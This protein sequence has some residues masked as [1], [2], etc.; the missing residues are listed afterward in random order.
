L[1]PFIILALE[2]TIGVMVGSATG[3]ASTWAKPGHVSARGERAWTGRRAKLRSCGKNGSG[4]GRSRSGAEKVSTCEFV[5]MLHI[6]LGCN[7]M[8]ADT[9]EGELGS[10][11]SGE[12]GAG[13]SI[14]GR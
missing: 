3:F 14:G 9:R 13:D 2:T 11:P 5:S 10:S 4:G 1:V 7:K 12:E 6:L 8:G